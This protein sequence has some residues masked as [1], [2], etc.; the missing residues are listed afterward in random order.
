MDDG[1]CYIR[2]KKPNAIIDTEWATIMEA[3][4]LKESVESV[5]RQWP[6]FGVGSFHIPRR[7][8]KRETVTL[9]SSET[10]ER[11]VLISAFIFKSLVVNVSGV[12]IPEAD[13]FLVHTQ[14][15]FTY[16][17]KVYPWGSAYHPSR[18][19]MLQAPAQG[20][21]LRPG[22]TW[23]LKLV[24]PEFYFSETSSI[25]LIIAGLGGQ[26]IRVIT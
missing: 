18:E 16:N 26:L 20:W 2:N 4:A 24:I 7:H 23:A 22:D 8:E 11:D 25:P 12:S 6:H 15:E 13:E 10:A 9:Y 3:K 19:R 21:V 1:E 17:Q 14:V 5:K